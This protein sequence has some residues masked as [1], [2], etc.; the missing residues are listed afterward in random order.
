MFQFPM[1]AVKM[2]HSDLIEQFDVS[3]LKKIAFGGSPLPSTIAAGIGDKFCLESLR[4]GSLHDLWHTFSN[5][6][7]LKK[8][9][10]VATF[11]LSETL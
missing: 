8:Q 4:H 7:I 5:A 10:T 1:Y 3:T 9:E 2:L 11:A 6:S